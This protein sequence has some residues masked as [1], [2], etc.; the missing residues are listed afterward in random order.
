MW[1][2]DFLTLGCGTHLGIPIV[3]V[4]GV[5]E[6][7]QGRIARARI[8]VGACSEIARRL[9]ALEEA[10]AG[11]ALDRDLARIVKPEHLATLSPI[12][13]LRGS[14][15]YRRQAALVLLRRSLGRLGM[16]A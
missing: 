7:A 3:M 11:Q 16:A 5:L 14:A 8:A 2:P 9:S 13:D 12:D 10:L 6:P 15:A 1:G 4:A